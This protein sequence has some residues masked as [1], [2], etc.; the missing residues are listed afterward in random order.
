M[1]ILHGRYYWRRKFI[2]FRNDFCRNCAAPRLAI[3]QRTLDVLHIFWIPVLPLG[4]WNRWHCATCGYP[5]HAPTR[6]RAFF[7]WALAAMMASI[8]ISGWLFTPSGRT[9]DAIVMWTMR[10]GGVGFAALATRWALKSRVEPRFEDEL[11]RVLPNTDTHCPICRLALVEE[12]EGWRCSRCRMLRT[13]V[14]A[15]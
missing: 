13:T 2:A 11:R 4:R 12:P 5:T 7:R 8:G 6:T 15:T 10:I 14:P 1:L 3:E 9:D